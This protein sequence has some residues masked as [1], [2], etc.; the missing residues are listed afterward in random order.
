MTTLKTWP[1][2]SRCD[3]EEGDNR[4]CPVHDT[5]EAQDQRR[6]A[7]EA[8]AREAATVRTP[9][10]ESRD[11]AIAKVNA[12]IAA[13]STRRKAELRRKALRLSGAW[14]NAD[15]DTCEI[16]FGEDEEIHTETEQWYVRDEMRRIAE[17]LYHKGNR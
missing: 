1:F 2:P 10:R 8:A 6:A 5:Q 9:T 16:S 7:R 14:L 15:A 3:C 17:G 11:A 4:G 12:D 13:I